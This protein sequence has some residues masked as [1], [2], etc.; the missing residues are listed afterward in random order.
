MLMSDSACAFVAHHARTIR[1]LRDTPI[2][3]ERTI[4][5]IGDTEDDLMTFA[6]RK[7]VH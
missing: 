2:A 1:I 7:N 3:K 5:R 6:A 4:R